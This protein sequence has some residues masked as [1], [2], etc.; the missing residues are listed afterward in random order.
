[1]YLIIYK[2]LYVKFNGAENAGF[3]SEANGT[4][5]ERNDV[6]Q[7]EY[8]TIKSTTMK[9]ERNLKWNGLR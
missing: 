2:I 8:P 7:A 9:K 3:F 4:H 5:D 1:L 6:A